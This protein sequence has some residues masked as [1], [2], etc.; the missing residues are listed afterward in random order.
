MT[1]ASTWRPLADGRKM[2]L[3]GLGVWQIGDDQ[4]CVKAVR[5]ALDS[6]Y[7]LLDTAQ[8]Y[9]TEASVGRALQ[10]S[11][12]PREDLFITTKF[13]PTEPDPVVALE[14]SLE[15]LG[16]DYVDLYLV[17]WPEKD[18]LWAWPG[19]ERARELGYARSIGVSNF[20]AAELE[21]LLSE[22]SVKPVVNQVQ[23]TPFE[24]R[25]ALLEQCTRHDVVLVSFHPLETGGHLD[26]T[27]QRIA[28]ELGRTPVQVLL[29]W[30]VQRGV[31]VIP[32]AERLDLIV[33]NAGIFE[34]VLLD[35][36]VAELDALDTT[37]GTAIAREE[38][39][40]QSA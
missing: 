16:V 39:W 21:R 31:P 29:R 24:Y 26:P 6:G 20:S 33:E 12:V 35:E 27:V 23:F 40:W 3:L 7:R 10:E 9:K 2:P 28:E 38:P 36:Q 15:R 17:H 37:G 34:F 14:A 11:A 32:R 19:L 1:D 30:S 13:L 4:Q 18:P 5:G 25:R 8:A 22:C